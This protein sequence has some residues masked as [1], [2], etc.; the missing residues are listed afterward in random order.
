MDSWS[1]F[2]TDD[3]LLIRRLKVIVII[4]SLAKLNVYTVVCG[5]VLGWAFF[6]FLKFILSLWG[7][8]FLKGCVMGRAVQCSSY[9][10]EV[11][12]AILLL[13]DWKKE[14]LLLSY[15]AQP[16]LY[17][18]NSFTFVWIS[19]ILVTEQYILRV[20]VFIHAPLFYKLIVYFS[21]S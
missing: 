21:S 3:S 4:G 8:F 18:L 16:H 14:R 10:M 20:S 1:L 5:L 6:F 15:P 13:P 19:E 11:Y 17:L 9:C 7:R 2:F 12:S